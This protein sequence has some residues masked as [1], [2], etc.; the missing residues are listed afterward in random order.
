MEAEPHLGPPGLH[1]CGKPRGQMTETHVTPHQPISTC[2]P[3]QPSS[4]H[5]LLAVLQWILT[6]SYQSRGAVM[7]TGTA[8]QVLSLPQACMAGHETLCPPQSGAIGVALACQASFSFSKPLPMGQAQGWVL[9]HLHGAG[10]LARTG[11][12]CH[13]DSKENSASSIHPGRVKTGPAQ[14]TQHFACTQFLG[15]PT[16]PLSKCSGWDPGGCDV[17]ARL[18]AARG[19]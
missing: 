3:F 15:R 11:G 12:R 10:E 9:V 16:W 13:Q 6:T 4:P 5:L 17:P 2:S 18:R 14:G 8:G 1:P 19:G 7:G